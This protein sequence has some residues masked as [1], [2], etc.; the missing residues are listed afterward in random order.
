[1][2]A[3]ANKASATSVGCHMSQD[4]RGLSALYWRKKRNKEKIKQTHTYDYVKF[5]TGRSSMMACRVSTVAN[6]LRDGGSNIHLHKNNSL[7][8]PFIIS[9][10]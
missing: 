9:K 5:R 3:M 2:F 4:S 1:M 7:L 6:V 10:L 8:K